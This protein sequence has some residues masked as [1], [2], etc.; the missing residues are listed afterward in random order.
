MWILTYRDKHGIMH[1]TAF[2]HKHKA[3]EFCDYLETGNVLY[4]LSYDPFV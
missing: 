1:T 3:E 4:Y 2:E